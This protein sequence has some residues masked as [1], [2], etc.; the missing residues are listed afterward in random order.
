MEAA[1]RV[2]LIRIKVANLARLDLVRSENT[3]EI[4]CT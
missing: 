2:G 4:L 1:N 3:G